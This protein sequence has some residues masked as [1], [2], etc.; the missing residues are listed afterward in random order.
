M[1]KTT[2]N[3]IIAGIVVAALGTATYFI[4]KRM[5]RNGSQ[6]EEDE[7]DKLTSGNTNVT[8]A[9]LPPTPFKNEAEGNKF[10]AWVND[11]Y[12][13]YAKEIDLDRTGAFNNSYIRKAWLKYGT[14]YQKASGSKD[15]GNRKLLDCL[16]INFTNRGIPF[17]KGK[18]SDGRPFIKLLLKKAGD[19]A[20]LFYVTYYE[21]G[22][23]YVS[24][25]F[26]E[27]PKKMSVSGSYDN[28]RCSTLG[29]WLIVKKGTN[30]SGVTL[31]GQE[32]YSVSGDK[33][34]PIQAVRNLLDSWQKGGSFLRNFN[35]YKATNF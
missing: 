27:E 18:E 6:D 22:N 21:S 34:N 30:R 11:N 8:E 17:K 23:F 15:L 31:V 16:I 13:K 5:L 2:R 29:E 3:W 28:G 32:F 33:T 26:P 9:D 20:N 19:N 1:T 35:E 10:R 7:F 25:K 4:V 14:L 24:G 12:P